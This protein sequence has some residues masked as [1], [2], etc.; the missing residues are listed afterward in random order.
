MYV[1]GLKMEWQR[2]T[3]YEKALQKGL[4]YEK[5]LPKDLVYEMES[6]LVKAYV[7]VSHLGLV[8]DS[9]YDSAWRLDLV[10][11]KA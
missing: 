7:M 2:V 9:V 1:K 4:E 3:V 8:C 6:H 5:V 10:C 11:E